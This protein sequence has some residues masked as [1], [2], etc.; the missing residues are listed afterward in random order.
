[1]RALAILLCA[2]GTLLGSA[3]AVAQ[4]AMTAD[5]LQQLCS[6]SDHVSRNACR[7]YILGITQGVQLGLG[8]AEGKGRKPCVPTAISA[9]SLEQ[10]VKTRLAKD[11]AAH[12]DNGSKDAGSFV[13]GVLH[14]TYPCP[15][16]AAQQ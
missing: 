7:I 4:E 8:M 11:L 16:A 10:S 1:M 3:H 5:D 6:G 13:A 15:R 2:A 12:P 9:E 14:E